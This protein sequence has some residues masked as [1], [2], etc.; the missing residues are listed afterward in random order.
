[1]SAAI[2]PYRTEIKQ[3]W[4]D[5][6]GHLSEAFYVLICGFAT[7]QLMIDI[8]LDE[9][10]RKT[11]GCSLYTVESHLRY[12]QEVGLGAEVE[13]RPRILGAAGKKLHIAYEMFHG[14]DLL[15]TEEVMCLHVDQEAGRAVEFPEEVLNRLKPLV[16]NVPDWSGR[17]ISM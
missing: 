15:F 14:E 9:E 16:K 12:L 1:M 8:G 7:D 3:E 10:Y 6:N 5:Y 2:A 4:I 17:S 11:T 13:V